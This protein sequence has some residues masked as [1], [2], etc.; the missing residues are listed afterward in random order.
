MNWGEL[1]EYLYEKSIDDVNFLQEAVT[2]WDMDE[3][4]Y[5]PVEMFDTCEADDILDAGHSFLGIKSPTEEGI[6]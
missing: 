3:G 4:E 1:L 2:V 5:Y 6:M